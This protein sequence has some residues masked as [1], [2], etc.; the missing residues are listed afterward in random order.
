MDPDE[1]GGPLPNR[2]SGARTEDPRRRMADA[3][4]VG[5]EERGQVEGDVGSP[6]PPGGDA[7]R[8]LRSKSC[9]IMALAPVLS[10]PKLIQRGTMRKHC[11]RQNPWRRW[12]Q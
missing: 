9:G 4:A 2:I 5:G 6:P 1:A 10:C 8:F 3:E 12:I 7:I 11:G